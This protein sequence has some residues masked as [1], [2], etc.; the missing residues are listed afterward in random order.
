MSRAEP[1]SRE[2]IGKTIDAVGKLGIR[3]TTLSEDDP[4]SAATSGLEPQE[5]GCGREQH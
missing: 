4:T 1:A 5:L 3:K 2:P